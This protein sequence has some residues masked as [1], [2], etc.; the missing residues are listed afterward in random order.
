MHLKP[1]TSRLS[2]YQHRSCIASNLVFFACLHFPLISSQ[3]W[4]EFMTVVGVS[5]MLHPLKA[6][7]MLAVEQLL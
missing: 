1:L 6:Q 3:I 7:E 5:L 4:Q 2:G